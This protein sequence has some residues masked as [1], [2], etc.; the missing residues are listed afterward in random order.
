V[1]TPSSTFDL[2]IESGEDIPIEERA[3]R[4]VTHPLGLQATPDEA[5]AFNPAFD[6]T[7]ARLIKAII[8]E[9]SVIEPVTRET[10]VD[11]L[12]NPLK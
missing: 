3:A 4:E 5:G 10:V 1:A 8:T 6:V 12:F 9:R 11:A 2:A 7:P